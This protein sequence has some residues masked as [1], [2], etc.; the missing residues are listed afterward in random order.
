MEQILWIDLEST[1]TRPEKDKIVQIAAFKTDMNLNKITETLECLV[2]PGIPIPEDSTVV[3]GVSDEMVVSAQSFAEIGPS[4]FSFIGPCHI[5]G[6]NVIFDIIMLQEEFKRIGLVFNLKGRMIIDPLQVLR[7]KEPRDQST[8]YTYYTGKKLEGAHH[9][10]ND[11]E[12]SL[13]IAKEQI[14]KYEDIS[15][16]SD[17]YTCTEPENRCDL[18][19][20]IVLKKGV[21]VFNFGPKFGEPIHEN[22]TLL[23]W[24]LT[25]D[26]PVDTMNWIE[27]YLNNNL[28]GT[29]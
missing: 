18:S 19:R 13:E 12:A 6:Y 11:I 29:T 5:A 27:N 14:I 8:V 16:V 21:P 3:H 1:G 15:N 7:A 25:K 20:K 28:N 9:A 10:K 26:F 22:L 17:L 24:M 2:N 4:L 23:N